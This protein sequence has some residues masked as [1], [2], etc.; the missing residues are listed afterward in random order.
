MS[1]TNRLRNLFSGGRL[2][3]DLDEELS[4]HL[5]A[6]SQRNIASGMTPQEARQDART[7]FGNRTLLKEDAHDMDIFKSVETV[8]QDL[9]YALRSL[10]K[11]P[12]FALTAILSLALGLGASTAI[13]SIADSLLLRPLPYRDPSR[14]M[15][16]WEAERTGAVKNNVISPGNYFDWK[17]RNTVFDSMAAFREK[18]AVLTYGGHSEELGNQSM[19]AELLPMLGV[20]PIRGRLFTRA[21]DAAAA[22]SGSVV[23]ISYRVWQSWFGADQNITGRQVQVNSTP[24]TIIGVMPPD[25]YFRNRAINLWEP[26]GLDPAENY[27]AHQGRW[28]LAIG[29]LKPAATRAQAQA[30]M[31]VIAQRLSASYPE[32][33][34][35][36]TVNVE[37]L[38]D[39][40][41]REV[42]RSLL[43]LLG[44]VGLLLVV[45]CANVANLLLAR[46]ASRRQEMAVRASLGA[47]RWR[48]VRQVLTE[49]LLLAI[50]GGLLGA[51]F[52]R[53]AIAGLLHL[54]PQTL[55]QSTRITVDT[56]VFLF[57]VALS[58]LTA[59]VF[60]LGPSLITSHLRP[61]TAGLLNA[62]AEGSRSTTSSGRLRRWLVTAEVALSIMLLAG[63]GLLFRSMIRLQQ[64]DP[65][66]DAS[67][68][69]TF[70]ISLP[71]VHYREIA[72][73]QQFFDRALHQ[74]DSLPGVLS[75]S[76]VSYLPFTGIGAGTSVSIAGRPKPLP[77]EQLSGVIRSVTPGYFRTLAI[78]LM[79][80][81]DFNDADNSER[82][83]YRFIVNQAFVTKYFAKQDPLGQS[84]STD[85]AEENTFGEIIGVVGNVKE[86]SV[87]K[88]AMPTVYYIYSHLPYAAMNVVVR[89]QHNPLSLALPVR[90]IV[91][92][93][94]LAQPIADINTLPELLGQTFARERFSAVLLTAF[95]LAA[96]LLASVGI[97][98]VLAYSVSERSREIGVRVALGAEPGR[99]LK[100]VLAAGLRLV[101]LG[102]VAGVAGALLLSGL[103]KSLLFGVAPHDPLT[104]LVTPA[105]FF[106]VALLAAF[107][108]ALRAARLD[109]MRVLRAQ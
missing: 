22:H 8:I 105:L 13:F 104:F 85:M 42:R 2:S 83:P 61:A 23:L 58:V 16:L 24:R 40:L 99:I 14:L 76:A 72:R 103:L 11:S 79:R 90:R 33:D 96:L 21:E 28:M 101:V 67:G 107:V 49:S 38:R 3:R 88:E 65:G 84:I 80:G 102:M 52:A 7:R 68:V 55:T 95:S 71:P 1:W 50:A 19:S 6:R 31:T 34:R 54:A 4:F 44:A 86:Q 75:A 66:L 27:R 74:I 15:M 87:D 48:I 53:W 109:P 9:R 41:V 97:Y 106:F 20:T 59:I 35:N 12:G 17:T 43:I 77:G 91:R 82:A 32:F 18:P 94:D 93:I 37:P 100:L 36:W 60:G 45:A 108:P 39:S 63:A 5:E 25:F 10:H 81:R 98:G 89:S 46:F 92:G 29:R 69:L 78:P 56:R 64:V 73:R 70:R 26:L 30:Q 62:L 47:S 57:S 51:L